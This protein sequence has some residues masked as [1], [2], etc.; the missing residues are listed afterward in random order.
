MLDLSGKEAA[1]LL[2]DETSHGDY[3]IKL[4]VNRCNLTGGI[5]FYQIIAG[6]FSEVKNDAY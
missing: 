4:V 1:V 3:E 2:N 6:S 5:F